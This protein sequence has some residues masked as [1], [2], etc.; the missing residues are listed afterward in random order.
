VLHDP[1]DGQVRRHQRLAGGLPVVEI[2]D[3]REDRLPE[4]VEPLDECR[5][6]VARLELRMEGREVAHGLTVP[7]G[8]CRRVVR[9]LLHSLQAGW[10]WQ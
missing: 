6:L 1:A 7:R 9:T 10:L 3:C 2:L 8:A 5:A 4:E